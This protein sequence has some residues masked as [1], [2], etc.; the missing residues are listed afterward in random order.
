[1]GF[2]AKVKNTFFTILEKH[3][4]VGN[5]EYAFSIKTRKTNFFTKTRKTRIP[6]KIQ[7]RTFLQKPENCIFPTKSKNTFFRQT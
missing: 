3:I 4:F 5:P 2:S 6:D 7:K 1:M